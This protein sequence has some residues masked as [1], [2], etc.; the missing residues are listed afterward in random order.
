MAAHRSWAVALSCLALTACGLGGPAYDPP[1]PHA[2][3]VRMSPLF[4]FVPNTLTIRRGDTVE[5][6]N[7]SPFT[8]TITTDP[9]MVDDPALVAVPDGVA[10]FHSG[11]IPAGETYR[12]TFSEPG[13]YKYSC[14]PHEGLGM[15]GIIV[16]TP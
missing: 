12:R 8:H 15:Q 6:R 10:P 1:T 5:W 11:D 14:Q 7:R 4:N 13:V 9:G 3:A 2:Y 16:V